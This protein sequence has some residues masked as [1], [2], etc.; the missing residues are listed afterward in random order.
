MIAVVTF[1]LG[2]FVALGFTALLSSRFAER[3]RGFM[4]EVWANSTI[5]SCP[6]HYFSKERDPGECA[7]CPWYTK[8]KGVMSNAE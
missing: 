3:L 4:W 2:P 8:C 7:D 1:F 5:M 6:G